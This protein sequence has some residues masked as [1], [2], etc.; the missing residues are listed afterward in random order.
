MQ[1]DQRAFLTEKERGQKCSNEMILCCDHA[2]PQ[3]F[4]HFAVT[5]RRE[6][7][8]RDRGV[9][10]WTGRPPLA[11]LIYVRAVYMSPHRSQ[12]DA[13]TLRSTNGEPKQQLRH[14]L[15]LLPRSALYNGLALIKRTPYRTRFM[16]LRTKVTAGS[17][18]KAP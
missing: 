8:Q 7:W 12:I 5:T 11:I 3:L 14:T 18:P 1:V 15:D 9:G 16:D 10:M 2:K 6:P 13:S 17:E 4:V